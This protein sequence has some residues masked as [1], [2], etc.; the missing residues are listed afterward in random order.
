MGVPQP[1]DRNYRNPCFFTVALQNTV[2]SRIIHFFFW[3][4]NRVFLWQQIGQCGKLHHGF[5]VNLDFSHGRA[6]LGGQK[7]S[8]SLVI[9]CFINT[10]RLMGEIEISRC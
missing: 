5:P 3:D 8:P 9:P 7:A 6:V 10:D 2:Y 1:M 4:K